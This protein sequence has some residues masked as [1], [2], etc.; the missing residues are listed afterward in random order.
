[1]KESRRINREGSRQGSNVD[2]SETRDRFD[3]RSTSGQRTIPDRLKRIE[4][5][6]EK[7]LENQI[8]LERRLDKIEKT[9]DDHTDMLEDIKDNIMGE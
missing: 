5:L 6:L 7:V 2:S 9:Q 1:V 8:N 4:E 3:G